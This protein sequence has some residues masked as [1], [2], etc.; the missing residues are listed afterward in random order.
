MIDGGSETSYKAASRAC[1]RAT[2]K[3]VLKKEGG[4]LSLPGAERAS[5]PAAA[6]IARLMLL[7]VTTM[8]TSPLCLPALLS[9]LFSI[10][11]SIMTI[12]G[13]GF[14]GQDLSSSAHYRPVLGLV[15]G[16]TGVDDDIR[17]V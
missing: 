5:S 8:T 1:A 9:R 2:E 13:A 17:R 6:C 16:A 15:W 11:S 7:H 10:A 3:G 14:P 12:I 4:R